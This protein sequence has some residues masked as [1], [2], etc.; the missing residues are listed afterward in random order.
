MTAYNGISASELSNVTWQKSRR[1][2]SQGNCVEMA[3]LSD[4]SIAVRNSRFPEGP[5]L[6]YT[7]AE[8]DALILGAKDGDFDNLLS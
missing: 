3:K 5:A 6:L 7:Q 4:G 2:N 8:I 1:S